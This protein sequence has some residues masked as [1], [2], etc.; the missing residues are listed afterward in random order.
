[1]YT[2]YHATLLQLLT[3]IVNSGDTEGREKSPRQQGV[4]RAS[5]TRVYVIADYLKSTLA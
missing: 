1:M 2:E 3:I 5:P 4:T